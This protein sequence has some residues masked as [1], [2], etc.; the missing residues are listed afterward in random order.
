MWG[1]RRRQRGVVGEE[2]GQVIIEMVIVLPLLL[3]LVFGIVEFALGWRTYHLVTN[4][5]REGARRAVVGAATADVEQVVRDRLAAGGLDPALATITISCQEDP[6][7]NGV[8]SGTDEV[9]QS[10]QVL[11]EYP[12]TF[13]L[14]GPIVNII[15]SG[16]GDEFGTITLAAQTV[17]RHE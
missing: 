16:C 12:F 17:M 6:A 2:R 8:C 13:F 4:S 14:I 5:S 15:C 1:R 9:G 11:V 10:D 3:L 7:D